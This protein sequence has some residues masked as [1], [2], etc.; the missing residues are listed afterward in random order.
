[1]L[2]A[3]FHTLNYNPDST[4]LGALRI[5]NGLFE[6]IEN[7]KPV[8][9]SEHVFVASPTKLYLKPDEGQ[10][11]IF[12]FANNFLIQDTQGKNI[13]Q[14]VANFGTT[15]N[16]TLVEAGNIIDQQVSIDY[17]EAG[18]KE[19]NFTAVFADDSQMSVS[20]KVYVGFVSSSYTPPIRFCASNNMAYQGYTF[21]PE[22]TYPV[23]G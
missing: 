12:N 13:I 20:A 11:V 23:K 18:W 10:P 7:G 5:V 16:Y 21:D 6:K 4:E 3:S 8:F 9:L 22:E 2:N 15:N 17:S 1:M 19:L 14:L